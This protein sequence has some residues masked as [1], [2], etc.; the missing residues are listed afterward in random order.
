MRLECIFAKSKNG[1]IGNKWKMPWPRNVEDLEKL[2]NKINPKS[3]E[4]AYICLM[5]RGTYETM[6]DYF[7]KAKKKWYPYARKTIVLSGSMEDEEWIEVFHSVPEFLQKYKYT[8]ELIMVLGWAATIESLA[9]YISKARITTFPEEYEW[10]TFAPHLPQWYIWEDREYLDNRDEKY[11]DSK[12][13]HEVWTPI[14][15]PTSRYILEVCGHEKQ[16]TQK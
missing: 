1:V 4:E 14:T 11:K 10:D 13:K 6:K 16:Y 3:N 8:D 5:W 12:L 2:K 15:D 9:K 7:P